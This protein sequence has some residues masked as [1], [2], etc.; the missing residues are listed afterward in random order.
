MESLTSA[1]AAG[2]LYAFFWLM[3]IASA[4]WMTMVMVGMG[5]HIEII[6]LGSVASFKLRRTGPKVVMGLFP[7]ASV[8]TNEDS[9][10]R[11]RLHSTACKL[12]HGGGQMLLWTAAACLLVGPTAAFTQI[13]SVVSGFFPATFSPWTLGPEVLQS[14]WAQFQATPRSGLAAFAAVH[15]WL[16]LLFVC[17]SMI[18]RYQENPVGAWS[19]F[20]IYA[21]VIPFFFCFPWVVALVKALL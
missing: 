2:L 10:Q 3:T 6:S 5:I 1:Q 20:R 7:S 11:E 17:F 12:L 19:H 21:A 18:H 8:G 16:N 4:A 9:G 13:Q 14:F 15:A